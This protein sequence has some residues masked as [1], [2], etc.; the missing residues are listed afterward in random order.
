MTRLI[1]TLLALSALSATAGLLVLNGRLVVLDGKAVNIEATTDLIPRDGLVAWYRGAGNATDSAGTN[2]ATFNGNAVYAAGKI[3][4]SFLMDG[5]AG[6]YVEAPDSSV[7]T[8]SDGTN[9]TGH[10]IAAWVNFANM[11]DRNP[12]AE[13]FQA[14]GYEW[15]FGSNGSFLMAWVQ[16]AGGAYRGRYVNPIATYMT[17]G[18]WHHV[19]W[20]YDGSG[21][22]DGSKIYIDGIQRDTAN[23]SSGTYTAMSNTA[24]TFG[25]GRTC[26]VLSATKGLTGSIDETLIY[27]RALTPAEIAILADPASYPPE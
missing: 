2:N 19:L 8:F 7:F 1:L 24:T 26:P 18:T 4:Q 6:T 12:V 10:T 13:K 16:N 15:A 27:N 20:V 25:L 22:T 3:G 9:D 11:S 23:L 14:S 17:T 5:A 21:T